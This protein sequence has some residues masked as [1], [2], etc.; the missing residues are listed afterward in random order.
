MSWVTDNE[1]AKELLLQ[2]GTCKYTDSRRIATPLKCVSFDDANTCTKHF[3]SLLQSLMKLSGDQVFHYI[4]LNPDPRQYFVAH[5][6][7]YPVLQF[8]ISDSSGQYLADLNEDPGGSPT[9]AIGTNCYEWVILPQSHMWFVHCLRSSGDSGGHLWLPESWIAK[10]SVIHPWLIYPSELEP[11]D[12]PT[13]PS[14][15]HK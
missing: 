3:H 13:W 11:N 9:D 15:T 7:K 1:K 12:D 4:V 8:H 10:V 6:K 5:F 14:Y 2:A